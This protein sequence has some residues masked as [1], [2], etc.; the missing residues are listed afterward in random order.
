MASW[1]ARR[2]LEAVR[3]VAGSPPGP[4]RTAGEAGT[5]ACRTTGSWIRPGSN[6]VYKSAITVI[7]SGRTAGMLTW[8]TFPQ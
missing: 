2:Y 8:G 7:S 6:A 4:F 1:S 3:P 5:P